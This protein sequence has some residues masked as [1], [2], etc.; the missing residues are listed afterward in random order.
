MNLDHTEDQ[1]ALCDHFQRFFERESTMELVRDTEALGFDAELWRRAVD[2]G[3]PGMCVPDAV[4]GGGGSLL[5][6][7]LVAEQFGRSIAPIPLVDHL[8]AGRLLARS[9]EAGTGAAAALDALLGAVVAGEALATVALTPAA[10]GTWSLVPAGAVADVVVGL[11]GDRLVASRS[12]PPG[13]AVPNHASSPLAHRSV[14]GEVIELATGQ[15]ALDAHRRALDE[16][17]ALTAAALVGI[18]DRSLEIGVGYVLA[19]R[20]FDRPIGSFQAVQHGLADV[21]GPLDGARFL[22]ARAGWAADHD[23]DAERQRWSAMAF[24]LAEEVATAASARALHYHGGYGVMTESDIQ[25][26]YRRARGWSLVWRDPAEELRDL[27]DLL[28]GTPAA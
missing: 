3:L 13:V 4:G 20:Q 18:A 8:T 6:G 2:T 25:L 24:V 9:A 12:T 15:A 21:V 1:L 11:D 14:T 7:V 23:G 5:D 16:W 28:F 19:R 17:K 10:G 22:A 27:G 26:L